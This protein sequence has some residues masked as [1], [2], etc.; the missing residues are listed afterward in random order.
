MKRKVRRRRGFGDPNG[1]RP[2]GGKMPIGRM[3]GCAGR[4][5]LVK[6]AV[7]QEPNA[8]PPSVPKRAWGDR[9]GAGG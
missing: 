7:F 5:G 9:G 4:F 1:V 6:M 3:R 2:R 8:L